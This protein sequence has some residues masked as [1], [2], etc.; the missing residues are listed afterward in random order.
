MHSRIIV[1]AAAGLALSACEEDYAETP[2]YAPNATAY[3]QAEEQPQEPQQ[4]PQQQSTVV[5]V[6]VPIQGGDVRVAAFGLVDMAPQGRSDQHISSLRVR[7]TLDNRSSGA[8]TL[9]TRQQKIDLPGYGTSVAAFAA[10]DPGSS[11]PSI[12]V[13][14]G[15]HRVID[16]FFPVPAQ[17]QSGGNMPQKFD[18]LWRVQTP[19]GAIDQRTAIDEGLAR[20]QQAEPQAQAA[21]PDSSRSSPSPTTTRASTPD[22]VGYHN[23]YYPYY[24]FG[25]AI[26]P[27]YIGGP[28]WFYHYPYWGHP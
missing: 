15:A 27:F 10:A 9:D 16:L 2:A 28:L 18:V 23:P 24:G 12:V 7:L 6:D 17:L 4:Q 25:V 8:W 21:E 19:A 5:R 20:Q 22:R 3:Q 11:P 14:P 26:S 13:Q 1:L